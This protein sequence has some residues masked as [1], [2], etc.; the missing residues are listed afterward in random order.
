[1]ILAMSFRPFYAA[2]GKP[3]VPAIN[4]EAAAFGRTRG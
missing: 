2:R 1:M 3:D 4:S